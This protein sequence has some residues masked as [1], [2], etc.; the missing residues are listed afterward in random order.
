MPFLLSRKE[1]SPVVID[2]ILI[3]LYPEPSGIFGGRFTD[4]FNPRKFGT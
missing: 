4:V 3:E 1:V 2:F